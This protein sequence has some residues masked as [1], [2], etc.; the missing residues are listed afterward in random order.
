MLLASL[1]TTEGKRDI[2]SSCSK[3]TWCKDILFIKSTH[4]MLTLCKGWQNI[5]N[6]VTNTCSYGE[7]SLDEDSE[8]GSFSKLAV[9]QMGHLPLFLCSP[10]HFTKA[11]CYLWEPGC[12][13][14][15]L[16]FVVVFKHCASL[17]GSHPAPRHGI[18]MAKKSDTFITRQSIKYTAFLSELLKGK[19][20]H[21]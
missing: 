14:C 20:G 15:L 12:S 16:F 11:K 19:Q 6:T 13:C 1:L 10:T 2:T 21:L 7:R 5:P 17:W 9:R 18:M 4:P 8:K 3:H